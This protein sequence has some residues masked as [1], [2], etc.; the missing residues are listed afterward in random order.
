L[1]DNGG[2]NL[3]VSA[4]GTFTFAKPVVTGSPY[5]VTVTNPSSPIVQTCVVTG[6]TGTMGM[7][8]VTT[9]AIVCTTTTY[10]LS[11]TLTGLDPKN[12]LTTSSVGGNI[13][14]AVGSDG[15]TL[16]F[17]NPIPSGT[18]YYGLDT[19][20]SGPDYQ[21]CFIPSI[22]ITNANATVTG[23]CGAVTYTV[24]GTITG[25]APGDTF[26]LQNEGDD[27][28]A[29]GNGTFT[30]NERWGTGSPYDVIVITDPA[31]PVKQTCVVTS[32]A[33]GTV[34]NA[35]ITTVDITCM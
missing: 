30:F 6:G 25:L 21:Y 33:M 16:T 29:Y 12:S 23:S 2:D 22:T 18:T 24:G 9:V 31:Y 27:Y 34:T 11:V 20:A 28:M 19:I 10:A 4:S 1:Q 15:G 14:F 13:T 35:N 8:P 7:A 5:A 26:T 32:G 3:V 17:P